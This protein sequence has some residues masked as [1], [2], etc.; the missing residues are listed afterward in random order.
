MEGGPGVEAG[1]GCS[2]GVRKTQPEF[3]VLNSTGNNSPD[4][5]ALWRASA[6]FSLSITRHYRKLKRSVRRKMHP[7][8]F[9]STSKD[10][11][12]SGQMRTPGTAS[13]ARVDGFEH[14][15][16]LLGIISDPTT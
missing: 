15:I 5:A 2:G 10:I 9:S 8:K 1:T 7:S 3:D 4:A 11:L 6:S 16:T 13:S 12:F 14:L